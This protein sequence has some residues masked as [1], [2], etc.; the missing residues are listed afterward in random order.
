MS[1]KY[2]VAG[3]VSGM[4]VYKCIDMAMKKNGTSC[5]K[6][7][8]DIENKAKKKM[9]CL[10]SKFQRFDFEKWKQKTTN[11]L[12]NWLEKIENLSEDM[13]MNE[14]QDLFKQMKSDESL[15]C[16]CYSD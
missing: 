15:N 14:S 16:D 2:F 4:I 6:I 1:I 3:M 5:R 12:K 10:N 7:I 9:D 13:L 11:Q 8:Q